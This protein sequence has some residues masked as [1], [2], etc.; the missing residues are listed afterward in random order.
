MEGPGNFSIATSESP[1]HQECITVSEAKF[2]ATRK[3][4]L[5]TLNW[6]RKTAAINFTYILAP[7]GRNTLVLQNVTK[8]TQYKEMIFKYFFS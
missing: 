5:S 3:P 6:K 1:I 8:D 4:A 7:F 2:Q